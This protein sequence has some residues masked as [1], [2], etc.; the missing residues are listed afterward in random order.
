MVDIFNVTSGSWS[1]I[2]L[3]IGCSNLAATTVSK[4][5]ALFTGDS[6]PS[7]EDCA[8]KSV[9]TWTFTMELTANGQTAHS[10]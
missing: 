7:S 3:S 10:Q 6:N 2:T 1:R 5:L 4:T 8:I 9:H